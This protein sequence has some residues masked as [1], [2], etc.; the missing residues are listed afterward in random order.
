VFDKEQVVKSAPLAAAMQGAQGNRHS[1]ALMSSELAGCEAAAAAHSR[2]AAVRWLLSLGTLSTQFWSDTR[3][4]RFFAELLVAL[5]SPAA[6]HHVPVVASDSLGPQSA[7]VSR[8][9]GGWCPRAHRPVIC[10][11]GRFF[12]REPFAFSSV[13][14]SAGLE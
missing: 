13:A 1:E 11:A 5:L 14:T 12:S 10:L 4:C 2:T 8:M 6:T 7:F 3:A 9:V